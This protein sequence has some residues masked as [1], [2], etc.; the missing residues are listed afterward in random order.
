[1][2]NSEIPEDSLDDVIRRLLLFEV[3]GFRG[4]LTEALEDEE[5]L[6]SI[7]FDTSEDSLEMFASNLE[8][9]TACKSVLSRE[10]WRV[11]ASGCFL[12]VFSFLSNDEDWDEVPSLSLAGLRLDLA[13]VPDP[14]TV[15]YRSG[16]S[17]YCRSK[18]LDL[19]E[20]ICFSA[21]L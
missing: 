3:D 1:L 15:G 19:S 9:F 10:R 12:L 2:K 18:W 5:M 7:D 8:D 13:N 11:F 4:C 20:V 6:S 21:A 17:I 16:S 14:L